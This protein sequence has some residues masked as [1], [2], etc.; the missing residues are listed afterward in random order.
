MDDIAYGRYSLIGLGLTIAL[1]AA[2]AAVAI[3]QPG[4]MQAAAEEVAADSRERGQ[5]IY[6]EAC[7]ECHG[8]QGEGSGGEIPPL[9]TKEFLTAATD[10]V[11]FNVI[12][13]GRPGT[14]MPAWGQN[15]GGPYNAQAIS[16]LVAF[17]RSWEP[18]APSLEGQP[19]VP[20]LT[21]GRILFSNTCFACHGL[22]GEGT[23]IAPALNDPEYLAKFDNDYL[24][25][26]IR[27]GR[28]ARGMPTWGTVLSPDQIEDVV[29]YIRSWETAAPEKSVLP[30]GD[31]S[32]GQDLFAVACVS[33][34]GVNGFGTNLAPSALGRPGFLVGVTDR[35]LFDLIAYGS[36]TMPGWKDVLSPAEIG[37]LVAY[38]RLLPPPPEPGELVGNVANGARLY[39]TGCTTCHGPSGEGVE[40]LGGPLRNVAS[41]EAASDEELQT[42]II[43]G[44]PQAGMPPWRGDLTPQEVTDLIALLRDWQRVLKPE[45]EA[46]APGPAGDPEAG[47][48]VFVEK[49][50]PC[51]GVEAEGTNFAPALRQSED[52][53]E[54]ADSDIRDVI[55]FGVANT[56]MGSFA[57]KLTVN[58]ID[59]LIAY[60]RN[61][62]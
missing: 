52:I 22:N 35:Q 6:L 32:R 12:N 49:C 39:A 56:M 29:A 19:Y 23:N 30:G 21:R 38:V 9:N 46:E 31:S 57:D 60:L 55:S 42:I 26:T 53:Q 3:V 54:M 37:D 48:V 28:A 58:Q 44:L 27:Q 33:C 25:K 47:Q 34:H 10:E 13:D 43:Q 18:T 2:L 16:D 20:D 36:A 45:A 59:D 24:R 1:I 50:S 51:H 11:I 61:I 17:I 7:A 14:S 8:Q 4:R 62:Q 40:G 41:L 5:E 15:R